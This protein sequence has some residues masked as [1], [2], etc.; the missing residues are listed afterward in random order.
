MP[1][2]ETISVPPSAP[3][4]LVVLASGTGS[5][6]QALLDAAVGDY[7]ARV[8]AVGVD[9]DCRAATIAG[10]AG[11][12]AYVVRLGDH[13]DRPAWDVA[14]TDATAVHAPD[15][16]VS[17]GFMKI[18]GPEFLSRFPGRVVNTHPALLP[19]FPGAHAVPD[20]L[21][22][23]VKVTGCTVHLVDAGMDTGPILAQEAVAVH[24][25]DDEQTLHERIKTVERRLLVDVL[26]ALATRGVTWNGRK[27]VIG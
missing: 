16:I 23:G 17:A 8:V 24:D 3:A 13:P 27:A 1:G 22:Y 10:E 11:I 5:L 6:L 2:P 14:V 4:R 20:A 18:L 26:A 15:L 19:S 21:A 7:P 9:R 25:G 12:P